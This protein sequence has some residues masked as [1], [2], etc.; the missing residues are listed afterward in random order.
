[1][2]A[3]QGIRLPFSF[4]TPR[5]NELVRYHDGLAFRAHGAEIHTWRW[6]EVAAIQ[7]N[8]TVHSG[9]HSG[10]RETEQQYTLTHSSGEAVILD[11]GLQELGQLIGP[12]KH[13]VNARLAPALLQRYQAD[14]TLTFGPVTVQRQHGLQLDGK[15]YA[16][17]SI[18]DIQV[19]DGRLKVTLRAGQKHEARVSAIPN[20]EVLCQLIGVKLESAFGLGHWV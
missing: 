3:H 9:A 7:S 15:T 5:A 17:N 12:V 14:E 13:A 10:V 6:D 4:G 20:I 8:V 18:Q 11:D 2:H 16:W 1:M 19:D